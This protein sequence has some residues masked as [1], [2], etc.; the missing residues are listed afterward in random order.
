MQTKVVITGGPGTGKSTVIKELESRNY[1][2]M[3]EISRKIT[4][5]AR[6][7][8]FKQLFITNPIQFSNLVLKGRIQ[9]FKD[10]EKLSKNIVF[11][12][13][14]IPD[15]SAYLHFGKEKLP[16]NYKQKN[17]LY[18][19]NSVFLMPP[20]EEIYASDNERY[21]N[22]EQAIAIHNCL[23]KTYIELGYTPIKVPTA[24]IKERTD[25]IL[26]HL[27]NA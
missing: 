24:T 23:E 1:A 25:F 8:G 9:Q 13:R 17:K 10:A 26:D 11:F 14:G 18:I 12:D 3:H 4:L 27:V 21:E 2:C 7:Q 15:V 19:Y 6:K 16:E 20:W 5:E 22:F